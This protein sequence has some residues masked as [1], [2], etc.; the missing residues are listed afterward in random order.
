MYYKI[1]LSYVIKCPKIVKM[2]RAHRS[3]KMNN[4]YLCYIE[5]ILQMNKKFN[6]FQKELFNFF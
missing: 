4:T 1:L 3:L 2:N 6:S 5:S